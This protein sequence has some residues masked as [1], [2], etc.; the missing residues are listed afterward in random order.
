MEEKIYQV[1]PRHLE[2]GGITEYEPHLQG[3]KSN[4]GNLKFICQRNV[5]FMWKTKYNYLH[6]TVLM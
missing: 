2:S 6:I 4:S 1:F 5:W 3:S